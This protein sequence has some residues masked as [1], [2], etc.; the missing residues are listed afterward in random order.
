MSD[1]LSELV[2]NTLKDLEN[3]HCVAIQEA[4]DG[5]DRTEPL[6]LGMIAAYYYITYTT[7]ELFSLSLRQKTN[8]RALLEILT[9]ASEFNDVPIR[10]KEEATLRKL[11]ERLPNQM[12]AQKWNDPHVKVSSCPVYTVTVLL[13][14]NLLLNAHL[15]RIQLT[16]ELN[17][18][19]E[20][21]VLRAARLVQA[22]VDVLSS[23]GWLTPAL[24]AMELSQMLTQAMYVAEHSLK[25]LPHYSLELLERCKNHG[26]KNVFD[27]L[28]LED[29]V[30]G[31]VLHMT[32]DQVRDVAKF[33][34]NYPSLEVESKV[35]TEAP[36]VGNPINLAVR[37][38]RDNDID[39][40]APPVV[41]PFYP[42]RNKEEGWWL[43]IGDPTNNQ[44]LT[45]KRLTVNK[46]NNMQLEFVLNSPGK[47]NLKLYLMS[48]S[49][50]GKL[51][52]LMWVFLM[53]QEPIKNS[54]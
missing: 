37:I 43:V 19:M 35:Q 22:C 50:L 11:S 5:N 3:S 32:E 47:H 48:D 30:R 51:W 15:S 28:E 29:D 36:S 10:H 46:E 6:N 21:A 20:K 42:Q 16:A 38:T 17:K 1:A 13:Q 23:N 9:N 54:T 40:M 27:L 44:L 34:N 12:K 41:A 14:V 45:I 53:F 31:E 39:G 24:H 18:D 4:E 7:I 26:V 8:L 25:Q 49:Y 52:Y 2:E 33:C